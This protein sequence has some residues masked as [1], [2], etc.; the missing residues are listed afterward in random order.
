MTIQCICVYNSCP[1]E[2]LRLSKL[3]DLSYILLAMLAST[4]QHRDMRELPLISFYS[5]IEGDLTV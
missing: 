5:V 4:S 1:C 2:K 3:R